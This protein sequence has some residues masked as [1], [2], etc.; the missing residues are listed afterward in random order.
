VQSGFSLEETTDSSL[1]SKSMF[2]KT[3]SN[4]A[5]TFRATRRHNREDNVLIISA[6]RTSDTACDVLFTGMSSLIC[7]VDLRYIRFSAVCSL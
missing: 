3:C 2:G 5:G 7:Q 4:V 6:V 1:D